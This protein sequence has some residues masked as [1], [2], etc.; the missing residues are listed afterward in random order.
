VATGLLPKDGISMPRFLVPT[1]PN[2]PLSTREDAQP[3]GEIALRRNATLSFIENAAF[4]PGIMEYDANYQNSQAFS[5]HFLDHMQNVVQLL[6]QRFPN[7]ASATE[8]GCGKGDFLHLLERDGHFAARGYDATYEGNDP[9]IERRYLTATDRI[10][11]DLVILRHVLEHVPQPHVFLNMLATVFGSATIYIEVPNFDWIVENET[12]FDITYEHVN[13]FSPAALANLFA[14]GA[15]SEAGL[16][17]EGQYQYV[18]ADLSR[19]SATF[20][21]AYEDAPWEAVGFDELFPHLQGKIDRVEAA[22]ANGR[23]GYLWGAATKGCMFLVHCAE[24]K[25]V[26]GNIKF[27][28]D[29]NPGKCGKFLPG[30]LVPIVPPVD[31]FTHASREGLLIVA[32][33]NYYDEIVGDVASSRLR[34]M[35]V[36]CL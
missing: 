13:Y 3:Y 35:E 20:P 23:E 24:R 9:A 26:I 14:P 21:V 22:L 33:P 34:D 4:D 30:S 15:V 31:F 19:L 16:L 29:V 17:F 2:S 32:N 8:V 6:K 36:M 27:A 10:D 28:I 25:N 7:G 12:F 1:V 11:T 5:G 18:I